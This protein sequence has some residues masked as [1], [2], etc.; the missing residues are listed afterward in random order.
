MNA[1]EIKKLYD[2]SKTRRVLAII[3][4]FIVILVAIV[5]SVSLGAAS[6]RFTEAMQAIFSRI[7]PFF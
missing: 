5:V 2:K 1:L 3:S 4:L 7:F 6:P